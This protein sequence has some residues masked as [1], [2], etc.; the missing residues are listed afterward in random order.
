MTSKSDTVDEEESTF[1]ISTTAKVKSKL[2]FH[3]YFT[4]PKK[5]S[6]RW[7]LGHGSSHRT[8]S[9]LHLDS[10]SLVWQKD[11]ILHYRLQDFFI[12]EQSCPT[13]IWRK[14]RRFIIMNSIK[15]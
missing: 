7:S 12:R 1:Y 14:A 15:A 13:F 10:R 11:S 4:N 9:P 8:L 3:R 2:M 5:G 6:C